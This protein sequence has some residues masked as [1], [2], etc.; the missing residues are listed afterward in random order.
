MNLIK[1]QR[2]SIILENNTAQQKL[3]NILNTLSKSLTELDIREHLHGDV[4]FA[5]LQ[6]LGFKHIK[7]IYLGEG[8]ITNIYNLPDSLTELKCSH[9]MLDNLENI[10][11]SLE[12]LDCQFNYLHHLEVFNLNKLKILHISHNQFQQ[13]ENLPSNLEELYCENNQIKNINLLENTNLRVLHASHNPVL[14]LENVPPSL[15]DIQMDNN[16]LTE[17]KNTDNNEEN[18]DSEVKINYLDSLHDYFKLKSKYETDLHDRRKKAFKLS[19]NKKMG[20]RAVS[21][22]QPMCVNCKRPV[23]TIF[24]L[25][26]NI[27]SAICGDTNLQTKCGLDIK[28]DSVGFS[29][30]VHLL[31]IFK[32]DI[33]DTKENI[34]KQK[35]DTIFNYVSE[36]IS[37]QLFKEKLKKYNENS[38][39]YGEL[40]NKYND[41]HN[42]KDRNE[43]IIKQQQDIYKLI[44]SIHEIMEK[45]KK[46][47]NKEIL[48][49]A[50]EIQIR[51]LFPEIEKLRRLKYPFMEMDNQV[52]MSEGVDQ[53]LIVNCILMQSDIHLSNLDYTFGQSQSVLKY[54]TN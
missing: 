33:D 15:L 31:Y 10:P 12:L 44:E 11:T 42:N 27:Y 48:H 20:K 53:K 26:N 7:R 2:E 34:I 6:D 9:N 14:I 19:P 23:G 13:I 40:L 25:E 21:K 38:A 49:K 22:I 24:S 36:R 39:M 45:Y 5:I 51:E 54:K 4:D 47:D 29:N 50:V 46:D 30:H 8:E 18:N 17:F 28:L 3:T 32:E 1:E 35:M 37:V 52:Y 43:L 41:L 16:P